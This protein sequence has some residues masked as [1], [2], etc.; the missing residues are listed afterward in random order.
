VAALA[1]WLSAIGFSTISF[2][3]WEAVWSVLVAVC[4]AGLAL[5][6]GTDRAFPA[7][8]APRARAWAIAGGVALAAAFATLESALLLAAGAAV[9]LAARRRWRAALWMGAAFVIALIVFWPGGVWHGSPLRS[10]AMAIYR[11]R[12][13]QEYA[14]AA[15][16]G[17][18][19]LFLPALFALLLALPWL[20][21]RDHR[22]VWR[23]SACLAVGGMYFAGVHKFLLDPVYLLPA[24]AP[25]L[26]LFGA[27]IDSPWLARR[28][29]LVWP[30]LVGLA[31][32]IGISAAQFNARGWFSSDFDDAG[33][34]QALTALRAQR[35]FVDGGHVY[36]FYLGGEGGGIESLTRGYDGRS[37]NVREAGEYRPLTNADVRGG[38]V[39]VQR[40]RPLDWA[41][42]EAGLLRGCARRDA[43]PLRLYDCR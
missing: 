18:A 41:A 9:E 15:D 12:L 29:L 6:S 40:E 34:E 20:V 30:G 13:G 36:K 28:R 33:F 16:L 39:A 7:E 2:H 17:A 38:L 22:A 8:T 42:L 10:Y 32:V 35:A 31:V 25:L 27:I 37:L 5:E 3:G 23:L 11:I 1:G 26:P 19:L 43:G 21:W 14:Q 24:L 4:L